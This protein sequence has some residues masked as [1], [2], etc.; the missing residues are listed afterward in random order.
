MEFGCL[1]FELYGF[2]PEFLNTVSSGINLLAMVFVISRAGVEL[3]LGR[4]A[5]CPRR[6]NLFLKRLLHG[7]AICKL[8]FK[9]RKFAGVP[10]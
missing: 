10:F 7:S 8:A 9:L 4:I 1:I 6:L 5:C 2:V 3:G